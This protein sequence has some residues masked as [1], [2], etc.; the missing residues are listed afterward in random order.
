MSYRS[1]LGVLVLWAAVSA[2]EPDT[3]LKAFIGNWEG[4]GRFYNVK[5]ADQMGPVSFELTITEDLTVTGSIGDSQLLPATLEVDEWNKGFTAECRI[6]GNP[7]SDKRFHKKYVILLLRPVE[8][9][10]ISGSDFHMKN[11]LFFDFS[12]RVG[13]MDLKRVP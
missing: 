7:F 9:D 11:N 2:Q 8:G 1:I 12:M 10:E 13:G 3:G 5:L 6:Q 4:T